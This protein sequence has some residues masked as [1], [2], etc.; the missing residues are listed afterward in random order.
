M[1]AIFGILRFDGA[2]AS[3]RDL[4]RMSN[5]M[6]HRGPEGRKFITDGAVGLGHCLMRVNKE[7]MFE[8]QPLRDRDADLTLVADARID[9]RE[10]LAATFGIG[11][12]DL[13]DMP[14][15]ALVMRAYKKWGED[16]AGHLIGDFAFAIWDGRLRKLFLARDHMAQRYVQFHRCQEFLVFATEVVALWAVAGV[17]RALSETMI[18]RHL[19]LAPPSEGRTLFKG[20]SS[21][22]GGTTLVVREDGAISTRRYWEPH[23]DPAH[24][25]R[26]EDE[27][28]E[29]FRSIV[30]EA[31]ECRI[32]RLNTAPALCLSAGYD[33]GAIAGLS[34]RV[35]EAQ[36]RKLIALSCVM[37]E[38]YDGP[39]Q[40]ARR[41]VELCRRDMPHIDV[42]YFVRNGKPRF[43]DLEGAFKR[44]GG[45]PGLA[46]D[47]DD[48]FCRWAA[49]AGARLIMD[50]LGGDDTINPRGGRAL[51]HLL[52]TGQ[53]ARFISELWAHRRT[54]GRSIG[55]ILRNDVIAN[56][57]PFWLRRAW[58]RVR[59]GSKP[60]WTDIHIAPRFAAALI[61]AGDIEAGEIPSPLQPFR[62]QRA[63]MY[64]TLRLWTGA[65]APPLANLAAA[66]GLDLTRPM[67]DKRVVEFGLAIPE[68]LHVKNGQARYLG[69]R[70]LADVY[71]VEFQTRRPNQDPFDPD[72]LDT[73]HAEQAALKAEFARLASNKSLGAYVDLDRMQNTIDALDAQQTSS[74]AKRHAL[75]ALNAAKYIA[76]FT[77][78]NI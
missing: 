7:D 74:R 4:E 2:E 19:L 1:S 22:S 57:I 69:R 10:E 68:S 37:S 43:A 5:T 40:H 12:V 61:E 72:F 44:F 56:V 13:C 32:R 33:S 73:L 45:I 46:H 75:R 42:R 18:G 62:A 3:S 55:Y 49:A 66:R 16:C 71:P 67:M 14:D 58:R 21:L 23:A 8:V 64:Q 9:N 63:A 54:R 48:T 41:W 70:A 11:T 6:A 39:L 15:S 20:I 76:W 59:H 52:R 47:T 28:I 78:Q 50:G 77:G 30:T 65:P 34:K 24:I 36:G 26:T 25:D 53:F 38:D 17:P 29:R 51:A 31:V 35:L 60:T 27:Y